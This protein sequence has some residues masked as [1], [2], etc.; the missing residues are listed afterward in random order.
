[1]NKNKQTRNRKGHGH[2][3]KTRA[4]HQGQPTDNKKHELSLIETEIQ[5]SVMD[6]HAQQS[7]FDP[8][9]LKDKDWIGGVTPLG[10]KLHTSHTLQDIV[11][12]Q[13]LRKHNPQVHWKAVKYEEGHLH[14]NAL[15]KE[16][17]VIPPDRE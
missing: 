6:T 8:H 17:E 14:P 5:H 13:R 1:M 2:H 16:K 15:I 11:R 9:S 10:S 3:K 4:K 7:F 12:E